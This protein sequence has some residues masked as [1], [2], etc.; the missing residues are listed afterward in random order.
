MNKPIFSTAAATYIVDAANESHLEW[1]ETICDEMANSA[2]ARGTGI[3]K[4][5]PEYLRKKMEEGKAI[6]AFSKEGDWAGFCYIETW[7]HGRFV[8]NSG[9]IVHPDHRKSGIATRIKWRTFELSRRKYPEAKIIGLTTSLAVMKIN[10]DLGYEPVSFSELPKDDAFW[11]GCESC[12]NF[13]ILTRT[14]RS[15]CLC[16]GMKYDHEEVENDKKKNKWNFLKESKIYE[17]YLKVKQRLLMKRENKEDSKK[18]SLLNYFGF[19]KSIETA[20]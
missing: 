1:A 9:L 8:A 6:I 2:K 13:D 16:T 10:S 5:S 12:V 15:N 20:S 7:D 4:R 14:N 19:K 18:A 11:K 3:A 17:G